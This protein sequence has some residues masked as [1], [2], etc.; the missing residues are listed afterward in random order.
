MVKELAQ[1]RYISAGDVDMV[2]IDCQDW[3]DSGELLTGTP[4]IVEVT[5]TALTLANKAVSTAALTING[6]SSAIGQAVQF[7]VSGQVAGVTYRIRVTVGT[8]STPARTKVFDIFLI[9][10]S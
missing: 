1:Q 2:A 6:R 7:K 5:T 9:T 10:V 4:T 8:N 3:L